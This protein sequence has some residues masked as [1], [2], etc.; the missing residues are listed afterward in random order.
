L[1]QNYLWGV[2]R[3]AKYYSNY[4]YR[5]QDNL[6]VSHQAEGFDYYDTL[7]WD[8]ALSGILCTLLISLRW[9]HRF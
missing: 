1:E 8:D 2:G 6:Q 9:V 4:K 7:G 3:S 5:G